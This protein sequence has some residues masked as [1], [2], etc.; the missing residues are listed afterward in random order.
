MKLQ[1]G[2]SQAGAQHSRSKRWAFGEPAGF[3]RVLDLIE[4]ACDGLLV[5]VA[6]Q[7]QA[8]EPV[9]R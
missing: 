5:Y 6:A 8:G 4:D 1:R 3:E 2:S 7:V 9:L